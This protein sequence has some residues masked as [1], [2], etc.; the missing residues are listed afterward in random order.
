MILMYSAN[1]YQ[2]FKFCEKSASYMYI[3]YMKATLDFL[4]SIN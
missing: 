1:V 3:Y 2:N 4:C